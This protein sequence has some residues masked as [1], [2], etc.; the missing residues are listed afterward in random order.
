M[1]YYIK[2]YKG[3]IPSLKNILA[4]NDLDVNLYFLKS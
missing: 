2:D 1:T 4:G 3:K